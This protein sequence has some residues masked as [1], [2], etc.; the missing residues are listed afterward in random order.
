MPIEYLEEVEFYEN[1]LHKGDFHH[2]TL[3]RAC[4]EKAEELGKS[5]KG[6][7]NKN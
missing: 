4:I 1:H 6:R 7:K 3:C 5:F 2:K